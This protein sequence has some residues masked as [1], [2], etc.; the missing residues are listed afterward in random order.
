MSLARVFGSPHRVRFVLATLGGIAAFAGAVAAILVGIGVL[1]PESRTPIALN[2][3]PAELVVGDALQI[4]G[5]NL[6]RVDKVVLT[7]PGHNPIA[8]NRTIES[9]FA[10][11][12]LDD[13]GDIS[14]STMEIRVSNV[15]GGEYNI[16]LELK[17][18]ETIP[19]GFTIRVDGATVPLPRGWAKFE[20]DHVVLWLPERY[21]PLNAEVEAEAERPAIE[22]LTDQ[23]GTTGVF[24]L[25]SDPSTMVMH[26]RE[27]LILNQLNNVVV[28]SK[29]VSF[30]ETLEGLLRQQILAF[31][32][33]SF[34]IRSG[35]ITSVGT[36]RA[37]KVIT[38]GSLQGISLSQ[39]VYSF[40]E[41][42]KL[43]V[44][45]YSSS[46]A[47]FDRQLRTFEQS[48]TTIFIKSN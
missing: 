26:D 3:I 11:E 13:R 36:Y 38:E 12:P 29:D 19:T 37:T 47:E 28:S 30:R 14:T 32:D 23:E 17:K 24:A 35:E 31:Q 34:E 25:A 15:V 39:L 46:G 42:S 40:R 22:G 18:G 45:T 7:A 33:L 10:T 20:N 2:V 21:G 8:F 6:D 43:H 27:S 41:G 44:V 4:V 5:E 48:A 9:L 16:H 1:P